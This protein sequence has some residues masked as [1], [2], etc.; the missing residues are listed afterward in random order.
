MVRG[1]PCSWQVVGAQPTSAE[2]AHGILRSFGDL[3]SEVV[4]EQLLL[5][6]PPAQPRIAYA[7]SGFQTALVS[8]DELSAALTDLICARA[9]GPGGG[10]EDADQQPT[11]KV[12]HFLGIGAFEE[13]AAAG[14]AE[15]IRLSDDGDSSD[16][17]LTESGVKAVRP[18]ETLSAPQ[19]VADIRLPGLPLE[20]QTQY[21]LLRALRDRGWIWEAL[22][23]RS[24]QPL[25]YELGGPKVWR[26]NGTLPQLGYLKCLLDAERLQADYG[27]QRIAHGR[28]A[29]FYDKL[30]G[31]RIEEEKDTTSAAAIE[32]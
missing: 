20:D 9:F 21:A 28:A 2:S 24:K 10:M 26:T 3:P 8:T 13:L 17:V 30:L 11:L 25:A 32:K 27:I 29:A 1:T 23:T 14:Y 6:T 19:R 5:W 4:E 31:G 15:Q 18:Q 12:Q 22:P 7:I 16:W